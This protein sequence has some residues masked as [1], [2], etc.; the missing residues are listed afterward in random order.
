MQAHVYDL[1]L[2]KRLQRIVFPIVLHQNHLCMACLSGNAFSLMFQYSWRTEGSQPI[3]QLHL[4][5]HTKVCKV[6]LVGTNLALMHMETQACLC[7]RACRH[8]TGTARSKG[9]AYGC[10]P[11]LKP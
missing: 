3:H 5:S 1:L 11:T 6:G 2:Q 10:A 9:Q 8:K 4:Y 7:L